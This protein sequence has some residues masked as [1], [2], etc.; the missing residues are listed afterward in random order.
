LIVL[1]STEDIHTGSEQINKG[2]CVSMYDRSDCSLEHTFAISGS[3]WLEFWPLI[4]SVLGCCLHPPFIFKEKP[5]NTRDW[6]FHPHTL[7]VTEILLNYRDADPPPLCPLRQLYTRFQ[8]GLYLRHTQVGIEKV[9]QISLCHV[10][11]FL[12]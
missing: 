12:K 8:S 1:C 11:L 5:I 9:T 7:S 3:E 6:F 2:Y 10:N 4:P